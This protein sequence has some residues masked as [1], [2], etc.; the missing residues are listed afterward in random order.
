MVQDLFVFQPPPPGM[1]TSRTTVP[2]ALVT[3]TRPPRATGSISE[4]VGTVIVPWKIS[5]SPF[6]PSSPFTL[7]D[8]AVMPPDGVFVHGSQASPMPSPSAS[9]CEGLPT[10]V[11]PVA[12]LG[13]V[14]VA[15]DGPAGG[16]RRRDLVGRTILVAAVARL[17][18]IAGPDCRAAHRRALHVG[19]TYVV[20]S[21]AGLCRVAHSGARPPLHGALR[22]G[23]TCGAGDRADLADV[24]LAGRR[25]AQRV[26]RLEVVDG[27]LFAWVVPSARTKEMPADAGRGKSAKWAAQATPGTQARIQHKQGLA[28]QQA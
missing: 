15:R 27:T 7:S 17:G 25:A 5:C 8:C 4:V 18:D 19:G 22:V 21:V 9:L 1:V 24:A 12:G 16:A 11:G 2:E 13:D 28:D 6:L 26:G 10:H 20:N 3:R 14:T 23:W